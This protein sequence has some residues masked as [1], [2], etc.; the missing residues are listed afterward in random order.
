MQ[1]CVFAGIYPIGE[2]LDENKAKEGNEFLAKLD[3]WRLWPDY[4]DPHNNFP[5]PVIDAGFYVNMNSKLLKK[6]IEKIFH[7]IGQKFVL[8]LILSM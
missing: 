5:G 7:Q 4:C 3:F 8:L 2:P 1:C 6:F